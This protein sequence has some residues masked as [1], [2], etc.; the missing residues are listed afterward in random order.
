VSVG[1]S[2]VLFQVIMTVLGLPMSGVGGYQCCSVS[3][4]NDSAESVHVQ[5]RWVQV[6]FYFR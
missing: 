3:G 1:T 4:D 5:Y 6:F 2:V